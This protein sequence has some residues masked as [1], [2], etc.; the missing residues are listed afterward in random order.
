MDG[1]AITVTNIPNKGRGY[2]AQRDLQAGDIILEEKSMQSS[3]FDGSIPVEPIP[4]I[5]DSC[6]LCLHTEHTKNLLPC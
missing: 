4:F 2:I 3:C 5:F 6:Y 1:P